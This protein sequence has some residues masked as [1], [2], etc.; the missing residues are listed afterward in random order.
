VKFSELAVN[1]G[2]TTI[3][4]NL[5][6]SF[7]HPEKSSSVTITFILER[8]IP[9]GKR[10]INVNC[11]MRKD[12]FGTNSYGHKKL[13]YIPSSGSHLNY[14]FDDLFFNLPFEIK[15]KIKFDKVSIVTRVE[16]FYIKKNP[17]ITE[18]N[19]GL[20]LSFKIGRSRSLQI[21]FFVI[22]LS[23]SVY[24]FLIIRYVSQLEIL[25]GTITSYFVSVWSIRALFGRSAMVFPTILDIYLILMSVVLM[26]GLLNKIIYRKIK[27]KN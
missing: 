24:V 3:K 1:Q 17:V 5:N 20:S 14:P 7:Y 6:I 9:Y 23:I 18:S 8:P 4:G 13:T 15:P 22:A 12:K 16:N 21:T 10:L 2:E 26:V 25:V 11:N 27:F 19:S